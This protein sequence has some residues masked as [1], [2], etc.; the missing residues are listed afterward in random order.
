[1][2]ISNGPSQAFAAPGVT[3]RAATGSAAGG[4]DG[5]ESAP[6]AK[7]FGQLLT[8]GNETTAAAAG[9]SAKDET[10]ADAAT[11]D[12]KDAKKS[13]EHNT[14]QSRPSSVTALLA[15]V[16]GLAL[17]N[18]GAHKSSEATGN[19]KAAMAASRGHGVSKAA[20]GQASGDTTV[21]SPADGQNAHALKSGDHGSGAT[22]TPAAHA[23]AKAG[24]MPATGQTTGGK[25]P[26]GTD[27]KAIPAQLQAAS[28]G[29]SAPATSPA[30]PP[31]R[32]GGNDPSRPDRFVGG[33]LSPAGMSRVGGP[34]ISGAGHERSVAAAG[35][36]TA[37]NGAAGAA[38][39]EKAV[40]AIAVSAAAK[41]AD[42]AAS[43]HRREHGTD[44]RASSKFDAA[45]SVTTHRPNEASA[46]F[47]PG[48]S[49]SPAGQQA[50]GAAAPSSAVDFK[51]VASR[52]SGPVKTLQL[53]LQP[54]ELG[55]VMARIRV[56][57]NTVS[58]DLK[59]DNATTADLLSRDSD[60][61][62]KAL[63]SAGIG[64]DMAVKV[65]ITDKG[66]AQVATSTGQQPQAS[67]QGFQGHAGGDR[68]GA[69][70]QR[71]GG[72]GQ[73]WQNGSAFAEQ[74][75]GGDGNQTPA[76]HRHIRGMVV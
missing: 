62:R 65:T 45:S 61:L 23:P 13:K 26:A 47:S 2:N 64:H 75:Q 39:H 31:A 1:M 9:S 15:T 41:N 36:Q 74:G 16:S 19:G 66:G 67:G 25:A 73:R 71:H 49:R 55:T 4:G 44:G 24:A 7:P 60:T 14:D 70:A 51:V 29:L 17:N 27:Q 68:S 42:N 5:A 63:Q 20:S 58:V 43:D 57:G 8:A 33:S 28:G 52:M 76:Q 69:D 30:G 32:G 18:A 40:G 22:S 48:A 38:G 50:A 72:G 12:N 11:K 34:T 35:G 37:G 59:A 46:L 21:P 56:D 10:S 54:L 53:Q 6:A 3:K